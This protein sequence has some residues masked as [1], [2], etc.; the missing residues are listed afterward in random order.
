[1]TT[2]RDRIVQ[3]IPQKGTDLVRLNATFSAEPREAFEQALGAILRSGTH[4]M[5][6]GVVLPKLPLP[7]LSSWKGRRS[8]AP[9]RC[10]RVDAKISSVA[11]DSDESRQVALPL[12]VLPLV[13]KMPS[14]VRA[15]SRRVSAAIKAVQ[16]VL[17]GFNVP[18]SQAL[19]RDELSVAPVAGGRRVAA[20]LRD[21]RGR[22]ISV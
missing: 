22:S 14:V 6:A 13:P 8:A 9:A 16:G 1:M 3:F 18:A 15:S 5:V 7:D 21:V 19:D 4:V 11:P 12:P 17:E 20:A 10:K 2:L